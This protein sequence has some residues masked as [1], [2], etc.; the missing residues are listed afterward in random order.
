MSDELFIVWD[1]DRDFPSLWNF[2]S[3]PGQKPLKISLLELTRYKNC[4]KEL[5]EVKEMLEEIEKRD[6]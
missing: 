4:M 2:P 6:G 5:E 1:E 3:H